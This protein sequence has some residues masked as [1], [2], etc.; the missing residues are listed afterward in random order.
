SDLIRISKKYEAYRQNV[1]EQQERE[2]QEQERQEALRK[3]EAERLEKQRLEQ[4]EEKKR[5]DAIAKEQAA[6]AESMRLVQEKIDREKAIMEAE[7]VNAEK[8]RAKM[9]YEESKQALIDCETEHEGQ[10]CYE[11]ALKK[12]EIVS[13]FLD[14]KV[15]LQTDKVIMEEMLNTEGV[16]ITATLNDG[17]KINIEPFIIKQALTKKQ[18][19]EE[20]TS[21]SVIQNYDFDEK[22]ACKNCFSKAVQQ[23]IKLLE[24]EI[25]EY[26]SSD[27]AETVSQIVELIN[28]RIKMPC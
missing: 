9:A 20:I 6:Q 8:Q 27:Y 23:I 19:S 13:E 15:I 18:Q 28:A 22:A 17:S 12:K 26:P 21:D 16:T 2:K 3:Q 11:A 14:K 25:L 5:L 1:L 24:D 7:R 4:E 10:T